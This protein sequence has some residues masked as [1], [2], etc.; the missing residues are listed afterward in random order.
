MIFAAGPEVTP[1]TLCSLIALPPIFSRQLLSEALVGIFFPLP[2]LPY[3]LPK[4][5]S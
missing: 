2:V 3:K 5:I 1:S 4:M